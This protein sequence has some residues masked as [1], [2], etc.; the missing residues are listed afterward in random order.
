MRKFPPLLFSFLFSVVAGVI[1][2]AAF[3]SASASSFRATQVV[4]NTAPQCSDTVDNDSD[5]LIDFPADPGCAS[6]SDND[7]T[8]T[9]GGGGGGDTT[10]PSIAVL[11]PADNAVNVSATTT[12]VIDFT[13]PV[14]IGTGNIKVKKSS[15]GSTV[16]T[17]A[18]TSA[19]AVLSPNSRLTVALSAPL[20]SAVSYYVELDGGI[21][22]D[23][24]GNALAGLSGPAAWNFTTTGD[25]APPV[26]SGLAAAPGILSADLSWTTNESALSSFFWGTTTDYASGSGIETVYALSHATTLSGL[27]PNTLYHYKIEARDASS[28]L[29]EALGSFTTLWPTDTTPP[30]NPSGFTAT[31][32]TAIVPFAI[33]LSWTNPSDPDFDTVQIRRSAIGYPATPSDGSLVY[34]GTMDG[35]TDT[36]VLSDVRYY[37]TAFARDTSLNYSSGAIASAIINSIPLVVPPPPVPPPTPGGTGG[38]SAPTTTPPVILPPPQVGTSTPAI[39]IPLSSLA[40]ADYDFAAEGKTIVPKENKVSISEKSELAISLRLGKTPPGAKLFIVSVTDPGTGKTSS[41]LLSKNKTGTEWTAIISPLPK[42]EYPVN[43]KI[44]DAYNEI[45]SDT[46]GSIKASAPLPQFLSFLPSAIAEN[47]VP[48]VEAAAPV[49]VPIGVAVGVTQAVMLAANVTSF[50]DLYLLFL[51]FIGLLTGLF[52]KKKPEPWGTVY[53]S[54]TKQPIDPAYVVVERADT[55]EKKT[56][57]TDLDGRY[58]FLLTPGHYALS[59]NKTHYKFPSEKL[60]GRTRDELYDNLYFGKSFELSENQILRYNV[61]LDPLEFD[62]NEFAK[63]K[64]KIFSLYSRKEKLRVMVFGALFYAGLAFAAYGTLLRPTK[65]N[66]AILAVYGAII[67]FQALWK[68]THKVTRLMDKATGQPIPFAIISAR[69][70]GMPTIARKVVSDRLGRFYLLVAPGT[71]DITVEEK[72]PDGTYA[73]LHTMKNTRLA[74]GVMTEDIAAG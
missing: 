21:V 14:I 32:G 68:Y 29:A 49:A 71:Y 43:I 13:E 54:V 52:R 24:S 2:S 27:S 28:N 72:Q 3:A 46:S 62:W 69:F 45:K 57:I 41:Y 63:N 44:Y 66:A 30:A 20:S 58:G 5:S 40:F 22:K 56:A 1:P 34:Q 36:A 61:P 70:A 12:L 19:Q 55:E 65:F 25:T 4:N 39:V 10:P 48:S 23:T 17:I 64:D 60:A 31:A 33:A 74:K 37:Y 51:K 42:G 47:I 67:V 50:Y 53:D 8:N 18:V 7:E 6:A 38:T 9:S 35:T 15:D 73:L 59:A 26:I 16:Q 11:S